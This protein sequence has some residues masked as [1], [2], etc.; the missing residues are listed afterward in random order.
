MCAASTI[1]AQVINVDFQPGG[2]GG[3]SSS[4]YTGQ[5]A[6]LDPGNNTWN[7]IAPSTD[8]SFNGGAGTGGFFNFSGDPL[9]SGPLVDDTGAATGI[10][11]DVFKGAP[12]GAFAVSTSSGT[13][14]NI[15]T[16]A[17][18]LMS[19]YLISMNRSASNPLFVNIN[20]LS[21]NATYDLYLYGAGDQSIR[22]TSF[23]IAGFGTQTTTG[24]PG[25]A[26][27]LTLGE[28][29]VVFSNVTAAAGFIGVGYYSGGN[30]TEGEFN[31]F[32]LVVVP[33]PTTGSLVLAAIFASGTL[34]KFRRRS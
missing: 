18:A 29:Y 15:A 10:S 30:S 11:L 6:Y 19:D 34:L 32:Q 16:N 8:G 17:A 9:H 5:G 31:G 28:D 1:N 14:P 4:N 20:G 22:N 23:T 27:S 13:Y 21:T 33:E 24:V 7:H 3:G 2:A 12:D 25:G 26:H